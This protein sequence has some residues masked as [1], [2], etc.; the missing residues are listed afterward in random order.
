MDISF[1][2][3]LAQIFSTSLVVS[4]AVFLMKSWFTHHLSKLEKNNLHELN[5]QLE[6]LKAQWTKETAKLNVHE[7]YLHKK[8]VEL[9]EDLYE[10]MLEAELELQNFLLHWWKV[11]QEINHG[12]IET[13]VDVVADESMKRRGEAFCEKFLYI[14]AVLHEKA[15]YFDDHF[16]E[17][18]L[19]AYKPLFDKVLD[20]NYKQ[21]STMPEEF[22]DI[23]NKGR[24]PRKEVIDMFRKTLGVIS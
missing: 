15:L 1:D 2:N 6:S 21:L 18:V 12:I 19:N 7:S 17:S 14:N 5:V 22:N 11:T 24:E 9:I 13:R 3:F 4:I 16:I 23:V 8:R 20:L 10:K